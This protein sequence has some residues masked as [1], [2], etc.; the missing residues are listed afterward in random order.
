MY[1]N[2]PTSGSY[3][4]PFTWRNQPIG[5]GGQQ[6]TGYQSAA[7][8]ATTG[9]MQPQAGLA[10]ALGLLTGGGGGGGG[11]GGQQSPKIASTPQPQTFGGQ[12]N[13]SLTTTPNFGTNFNLSSSGSSGGSSSGSSSSSSSRSTRQTLAP[14][15][16]QNLNVAAAM[17]MLGD[18]NSL[19][20]LQMN[21][22]LAQ[23]GMLNPVGQGMGPAQ[24]SLMQNAGGLGGLPNPGIMQQA[25]MIDAGVLGGLNIGGGSG[26]GGGGTSVGVDYRG[27]PYNQAAHQ[28]G[29]NAL[30]AFAEAENQRL[31]AATQLAIAQEQ[32]RIEAERANTERALAQLQFE[33]FDFGREAIGNIPGYDQALAQ[34]LGVSGGDT[35]VDPTGVLSPQ[36][37]QALINLNRANTG[38]S[39]AGQVNRMR[40]S[41]A[42]RGF[43]SNSGAAVMAQALLE[44]IGRASAEQSATQTRVDASKLNAE[45]ILNQQGLQADIEQRYRQAALDLIRGQQS[46]LAAFI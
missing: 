45:H 4:S 43:G 28:T 15:G 41:F 46:L 17:G 10:Q 29:Q 24:S 20:M 44:A 42:G 36:D 30:L 9:G 33:R 3:V 2:Q 8:P 13:A 16:S 25:Q 18:S 40:D 34:V 22:R 37:L 35:R 38:Q 11:G 39:V 12:T 26:P 23:V 19:D 5:L 32:S 31:E 21:A 7:T 1:W 14:I 27:T 6:L